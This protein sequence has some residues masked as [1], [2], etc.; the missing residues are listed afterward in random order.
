VVNGL[1]TA[2][3]FR[4]ASAGSAEWML[5]GYVGIAQGRRGVGLRVSLSV[6][7]ANADAAAVEASVTACH[8]RRRR[9]VRR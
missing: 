5:L 8:G 3:C 1:K 4:V 7:P 9:E 6:V 2:R